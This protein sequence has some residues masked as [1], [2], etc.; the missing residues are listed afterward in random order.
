MGI[1]QSLKGFGTLVISVVPIVWTVITAPLALI[2]AISDLLN[3]EG[4]VL[5]PIDTYRS[6]MGEVAALLHLPS[7]LSGWAGDLLI[8]GILAAVLGWLFFTK[9]YLE[10]R[11]QRR[12]ANE[13]RAIAVNPQD[14][15]T[16][17]TDYLLLGTT[18]AGLLIGGGVSH[19]MLATGAAM[20]GTGPIGWVIGPFAVAGVGIWAL[21]KRQEKREAAALAHAESESRRL[22]AEQHAIAD[23]N[24]RMYRARE[25]H[26]LFIASG[27]IVLLVTLNFALPWIIDRLG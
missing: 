14:V 16:D 17:T 22:A 5:K 19:M 4:L 20:A 15:Q 18:G 11:E 10:A 9:L 25:R 6:A 7:A 13:G 2:S 27:I 12:A 3:I 26:R 1:S 23:S 8:V 24:I 21:T